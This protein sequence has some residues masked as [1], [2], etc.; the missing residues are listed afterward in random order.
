MSFAEVMLVSV[1]SF[2]FPRR[3]KF[4]YFFPIF[5][6][7]PKNKKPPNTKHTTRIIL[8]GFP[9]GNIGITHSAVISATVSKMYIKAA[10][11]EKGQKVKNTI[12]FLWVETFQMKISALLNK[13]ITLTMEI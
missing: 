4:K 8:F 11:T 9:S 2:S 7:N 5:D 6:N 13:I 10:R 12:T 3:M 1:D